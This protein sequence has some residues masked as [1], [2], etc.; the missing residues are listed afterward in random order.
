MQRGLM[1]T[2][3][4][5]VAWAGFAPTATRAQNASD[6]VTL[7]TLSVEG[8]GI[9]RNAAGSQPGGAVGPVRGYVAT[10]SRVA[11]KTDT[12]ILETAQ[13]ISVIGRQQI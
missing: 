5:G 6:T 13:S 1:L 9:G 11:T 3:L 2:L 8:V 4:S 7:D 12:P 10:Q